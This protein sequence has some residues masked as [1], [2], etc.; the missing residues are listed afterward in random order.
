MKTPK[1]HYK[2]AGFDIDNEFHTS[3]LISEVLSCNKSSQRLQIIIDSIRY[4]ETPKESR[5]RW[6]RYAK[7]R[8]YKDDNGN[9]LSEDSYRYDECI[10]LT[11][12]EKLKQ[13]HEA[14]LQEY[15]KG[16]PSQLTF[17]F[18]VSPQT[19]PFSQYLFQV[20]YEY[21]P[22]FTGTPEDGYWMGYIRNE[23]LFEK[24]GGGRENNIWIQFGFSDYKNNLKYIIEGISRYLSG[25]KHL[26]Y[27]DYCLLSPDMT[28]EDVYNIKTENLKR[29]KD[30]IIEYKEQLELEMQIRLSNL[31]SENL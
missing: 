3:H 20:Q 4:L 18:Y 23:T 12:E 1:R 15:V 19:G 6:D 10:A 21:N 27:N 13:L 29:K 25:E 9:L 22:G 8:L 28:D 11:T 16:N 2:L 5:Y 31:E 30:D 14:K 17:K 7:E 24:R 26:V